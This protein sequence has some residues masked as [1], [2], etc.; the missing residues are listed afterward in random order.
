MTGKSG[1]AWQK[2]KILA[3]CSP[4]NH[5]RARFM[6][7]E[8]RVAPIQQ[9]GRIRKPAKTFVLACLGTQG[10]GAVQTGR[11]TKISIANQ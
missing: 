3:S 4:H 9:P 7:T 6:P 10:S 2:T 11:S 8:S 1:E 5:P